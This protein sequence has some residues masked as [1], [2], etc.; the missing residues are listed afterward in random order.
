MAPKILVLGGT[1]A[2]RASIQEHF[3]YISNLKPAEA[4]RGQ[5]SKQEKKITIAYFTKLT[6]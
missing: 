2:E 6:K 1:K 4:I 5:S 3:A